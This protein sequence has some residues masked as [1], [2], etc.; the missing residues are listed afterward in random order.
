MVV[1]LGYSAFMDKGAPVEPP[2]NDRPA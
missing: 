2:A 1:L